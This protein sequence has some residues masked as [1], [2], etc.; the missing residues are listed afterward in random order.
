MEK[1]H[2]SYQ[3]DIQILGA[4][5]TV[6]GSKYYLEVG[7]S[8]ILID[9]GVF[10]GLKSLREENWDDLAI[11]V[12]SLDMVLL[13]HG[14]LDHVGYLPRLFAQGFRG[15]I[16]ATAPTLAIAKI[17][18]EDSAKIHEEDAIRANEEGYTRHQ[19]AKPYYTVKT[20]QQCMAL[21]S[22]VQDQEWIQLQTYLSV[23]FNPVG[24]ILGACFIELDI[25][26][27]RFVFSGDVGR[28]KDYLLNPPLKPRWADVL[29]LESTY[30]DR[31]HDRVDIPQILQNYL[32]K[33]IHKRGALIIPSFAVE[34]LQTLMYI[35]WKGYIDRQLPYVPIYVDSPMGTNVLALFERF[36]KWHKLTSK[37][38]Q[39]MCNH[40]HMVTSYKETWEV[41]DKPNPKIVIAGSGMVTGG[42]VLTYLK[43]YIDHPD[44]HVLLVGYQA[45]GT[46][47]RQLQDGVHE[48]KIHG[49]YFPVKAVV[50][51]LDGLSA[52][53]DQH[54]LLDWLADI[55]N[56]PEQVFLTHG[57]AASCDAF[58]VKL[59]HLKK[60]PV[61]VPNPYQQFSFYA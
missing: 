11:D 48:L 27:K 10:Q 9:C 29:F 21:F 4:A 49:K 39:A 57:E 24:H 33:I 43:Q 31:L 34:R 51:T 58:R 53:A 28:P 15:K 60:W 1:T 42:R 44:T 54:E 17:I 3:V 47:G 12:P 52:H 36:K 61:T 40:I 19:P 56:I 5:K 18:L 22:P 7:D 14:H 55:R 6:T 2:H 45:Q 59:E 25:N 41:I 20:A 30:G 13:T 37:E 46:R 8:R 35:L 38:Y 32:Q 16:L 50:H 23:R 26:G